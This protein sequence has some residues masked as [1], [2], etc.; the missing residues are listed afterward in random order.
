M[1]HG[2]IPVIMHCFSGSPE[3]A[4]RCIKEG[5]Y[6]AFGGVLTFKNAK[7]AKEIAQNIPLEYLLLETDDPYLIWLSEVILQQ[8]RVEQGLPYYL[9]FVRHYPT[10]RDLASAREDDVLRD[11]QGL[12]YYSR[13]RHLHQAAQ[14]AV[15]KAESTTAKEVAKRITTI[16][17]R[18]LKLGPQQEFIIYNQLEEISKNKYDNY[19]KK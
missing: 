17:K 16:L 18:I 15:A 10:I 5:W 12:G 13:A 8:T 9:R 3:F 4:E 14:K 7:N 6:L 11:W 2:E 1:I 19:N